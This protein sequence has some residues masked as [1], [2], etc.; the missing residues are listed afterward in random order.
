M[1]YIGRDGELAL[2]MDT[3]EVAI[4]DAFGDVAEATHGGREQACRQRMTIAAP[5]RNG[6]AHGQ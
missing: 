1:A 5:L 3:G 2:L 4:L 6:S